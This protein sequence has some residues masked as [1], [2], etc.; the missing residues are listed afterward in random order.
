M[1][2]AVFALSAVALLRFRVNSVWLISAAAAG[3]WLLQ[4]VR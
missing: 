4:A 3:G 1:T 2:I